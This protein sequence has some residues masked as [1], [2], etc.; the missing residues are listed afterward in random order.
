MQEA[1]SPYGR[2]E[3]YNMSLHVKPTTEFSVSESANGTRDLIQIGSLDIFLTRE[4]LIQLGEA[5]A[6]HTGGTFMP[7]GS[8]LAVAK[9][10]SGQ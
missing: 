3:S 9:A 10:W 6:V 5:I 2:N 7:P 4:D 8:V 1:L